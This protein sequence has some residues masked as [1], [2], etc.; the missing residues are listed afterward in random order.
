MKLWK[1]FLAVL[2][3]SIWDVQTP[4]ALGNVNTSLISRQEKLYLTARGDFF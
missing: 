3:L 1:S 2:I 4:L